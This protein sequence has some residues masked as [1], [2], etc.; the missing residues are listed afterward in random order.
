MTV[1]TERLAH[2]VLDHLADRNMRWG[3]LRRSLSILTGPQAGRDA[4]RLSPYIALSREAGAGGELIARQVGDRLGWRVFDKELLGFLA[5][6]CRLDRESLALLD[7]TKVSWFDESVLNLMKPHLPSQDDY[8]RRIVKI[9]VLAL[10]EGPAVLVGRG[11]QAVLPRNLGLS[12]RVVAEEKDRL[13]RVC[14]AQGLSEKAGRKY[15]QETDS[16]R[17]D[18]VRRHFHIDAADPLHYDLTLNTSRLDAAAA[19]EVVLAMARA[20]GLVG[21]G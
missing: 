13:A 5:D 14:E 16:A 20:R 19:T 1:T 7:E 12:I 3:E 9:V 6:Q 2:G 10:I 18:F 8:V 17:Q 4:A 21:E 15:L 11:M